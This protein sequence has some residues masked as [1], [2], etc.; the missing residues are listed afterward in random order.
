VENT[1][2]RT[3]VEKIPRLA[4]VV[5]AQVLESISWLSLWY[6]YGK[7]KIERREKENNTS[8]SGLHD[9]FPRRLEEEREKTNG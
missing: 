4:K 1:W 2:L 6:L 9:F 8:Q 7:K 5:E 3:A